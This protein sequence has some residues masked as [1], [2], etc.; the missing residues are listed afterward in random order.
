MQAPPLAHSLS[1]E[2]PTHWPSLHD[3]PKGQ[4]P[5]SS[6]PP[7]PSGADPHVRPKAAQV[8]GVQEETQLPLWQTWPAPQQV[9]P[10]QT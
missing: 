10:Q 6:V 2:H 5:Q 1:C 3:L 7:Q 9:V 4:P 8:V